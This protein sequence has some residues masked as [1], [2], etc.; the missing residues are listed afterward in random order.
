MRIIDEANNLYMD[1]LLDPNAKGVQIF[2][3]VLYDADP[4]L[5]IDGD[6]KAVAC[7]RALRLMIEASER[8]VFSGS[9]T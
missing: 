9:L 6:A 7:E 3:G 2:M 1:I 4:P 8:P 5:Q